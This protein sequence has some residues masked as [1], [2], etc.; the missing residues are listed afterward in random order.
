MIRRE[1]L[2]SRVFDYLIAQIKSGQVKPGEK[3]PTEKEL[4]QTLG[5][6]RTCVREAMKSLQALQLV[7][8]R[9]AV[10]AV[11]NEPAP[12]TWFNADLFAATIHSDR[13]STRL[14]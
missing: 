6:S 1:T 4:T 12:G 8:I 5:V 2:T 7:S 3:L 13:K 9:A 14:N 11:V 10:G